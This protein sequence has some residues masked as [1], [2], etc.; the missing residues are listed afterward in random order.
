MEEQKKGRGPEGSYSSYEAMIC[1]I[2]QEAI[3]RARLMDERIVAE[4]YAERQIADT[5]SKV[6]PI[7][8]KIKE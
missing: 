8:T 5:L 6:E 7:N 1:R 4:G 2:R 3:E